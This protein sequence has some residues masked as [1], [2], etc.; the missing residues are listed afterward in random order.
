MGDMSGCT[1]FDI[2]GV[3]SLVEKR[4]FAAGFS[5]TGLRQELDFSEVSPLLL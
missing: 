5:R 3:W 4:Y 2:P 1:L